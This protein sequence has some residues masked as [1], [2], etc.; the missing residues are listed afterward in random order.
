MLRGFYNAASGMTAQQRKTD[1]LNNNIA[2]ANTPGYKSDQSAIR[3]FPE[4]LLH[5]ENAGRGPHT[6]GSLG[7]GVYMQDQA[8]SFTPGELQETNAPADVALLEAEVPDENGAVL[9][10]VQG[11]DG[12]A[13]TRNGNWTVDAEGFL[14]TAE[15]QYI[16]NN[17][18]APVETGNENFQIT[19]DGTVL[20]ENGGEAGQLGVAYAPDTNDLVKTEAGLF[21][22]EEELGAAADNEDVRYQMKQGFLEQSNT[23]STQ[24]MTELM[25]A[26]RMFESN[27]KVMQT[28]DRSMEKA[29]NEVGRLG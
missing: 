22:A 17:E 21:E 20:L 29:V 4:Q 27:Q 26:Y 11:E 23:D 12:T 8:P 1:M 25:E 19:E 18:G 16:L 10:T 28:Y 3:T 13:Y 14:T 6:I 9:F 2:N 15:G 5:A 7:T 24:A